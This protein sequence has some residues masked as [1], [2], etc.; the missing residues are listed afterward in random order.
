ML[1]LIYKTTKVLL[2]TSSDNLVMQLKVKLDI[3]K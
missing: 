1:S 2:H 3:T